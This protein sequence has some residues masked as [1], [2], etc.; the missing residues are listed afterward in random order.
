MLNGNS[1]TGKDQCGNIVTAGGVLNFND[2][3]SQGYI[4]GNGTN[5]PG[6]DFVFDNCSETVRVCVFPPIIK[7][8]YSRESQPF[9]YNPNSQIMISY[10]NPDSFGMMFLLYVFLRY[11]LIYFVFF[12]YLKPGLKGTFIKENNLAGFAIWPANGDPAGTL[13]DGISSKLDI[14]ACTS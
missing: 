10:D 13:L 3:I 4:T 11:W 6:I 14:K 8:C 9:V 2:M 1:P 7:T 5:A 12:Y